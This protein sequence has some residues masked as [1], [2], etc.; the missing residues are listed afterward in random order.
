MAAGDRA[1]TA[2]QRIPAITARRG[3]TWTRSDPLQYGPLQT[4]RVSAGGDGKR[5]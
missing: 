5:R 4:L 1:L 3:G 2:L